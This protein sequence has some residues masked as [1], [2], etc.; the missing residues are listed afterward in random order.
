MEYENMQFNTNNHHGFSFKKRF[1]FFS[2]LS[3]LLISVLFIGYFLSALS[4][5]SQVVDVKPIEIKSG[6]GFRSISQNLA[7]LEIIRSSSV[8]KIIA[9][10]SG[11]A[12][13]L[14]PGKY[15]LDSSLSSLEILNLLIVGPDIE[16]E[17]VIPEGFTLL[18]IDKR[19]SDAGIIMVNSLA[20]FNFD[21]LKNEYEFLKELKSPIKTI[22]GYLFPDTYKFFVNSDPGIVIRK[23]LDN[24]NERAWIF[25]KNQNVTAGN[26]TFNP[27]QI[28]IIASLIEKEVYYKDEKALV[29]GVIYERLKIGMPIQID[30]TITYAKCGG[31]I[32][33]CDRP[34]IAKSE[35]SFDSPYNTYLHNGLPP[36][37]ISNPGK[38]SISAAIYPEH[39]N[40]LYYLSDPE[41]HKIIFSETFE[42]HNE[43]R[44]VYLDL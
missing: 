3:V 35:L 42:E 29:A 18:D 37:P 28:L 16:R 38:D 19:L 31:F 11:S 23:F 2:F 32:F 14:K 7:N 10:I 24:F 30:A 4:P 17:V 12:H 1:F 43:N 44:D 40:Y 39:S 5:V 22:E 20:D 34:A 25:L 36:T 26:K 15:L 9:F 41:T 33:Y 27:N 6:D 13:K 21:S 8:F